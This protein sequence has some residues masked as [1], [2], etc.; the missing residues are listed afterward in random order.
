MLR[1]RPAPF[2]AAG[3]YG[4][5]VSRRAVNS[6]MAHI[7]TKPG[8]PS[9]SAAVAVAARDCLSAR[10]KSEPIRLREG[11][12]RT[13]HGSEHSDVRWSCSHKGRTGHRARGLSA[14]I[15]SQSGVVLLKDVSDG[16]DSTGAGRL[17]P[18]I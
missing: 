17:K 8:T 16:Y 11:S 13:W 3:R 2:T 6:H 12:S 7:L 1:N 4:L 10:S 5:F 18:A 14:A 15:E 9:R